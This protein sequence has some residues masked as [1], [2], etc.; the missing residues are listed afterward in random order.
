MYV[1]RR[2]RTRAWGRG[3]RGG[4]RG[5]RGRR[6]RG[7]VARRPPACPR[8]L[9]SSS[10]AGAPPGTRRNDSS[11]RRRQRRPQTDRTRP[12]PRHDPSVLSPRYSRTV[13]AS[14]GSERALT[15]HLS[16]DRATEPLNYRSALRCT[17]RIHSPP[18]HT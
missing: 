1:S 7:A 12:T 6:A 5:A 11:S 10:T 17:L 4:A 2:R 9:A 15:G 16:F 8:T 3:G 13:C 14:G 18:I